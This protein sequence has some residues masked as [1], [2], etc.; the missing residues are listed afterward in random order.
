MEETIQNVV[1]LHDP[2]LVEDTNSDPVLTRLADIVL[3]HRG[4]PMEQCLYENAIVEARR[5]SDNSLPPGYKDKD[6]WKREGLEGGAGDYIVWEQFLQESAKRSVD[7]VFVTGDVKED[8]YVIQSGEAR[9]PR[10]ELAEEYASRTDGHRLFMIRSDS[11]I[12]HYSQIAKLTPVP[13]ASGSLGWTESGVKRLLTDLESGG[14]IA[15]ARVIL[16][17]IATGES[18]SRDRVYELANYPE[19]RSLRGFTRPVDRIM[20][21]MQNDGQ[22]EYYTETPLIPEYNFTETKN[23]QA[24]SFRLTSAFAN[25]ARQSGV[26]GLSPIELQDENIFVLQDDDDVW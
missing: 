2:D 17:S 22:I 23:N 16:E 6:K 3:G 25:A 18:V 21:D 26:A 5:R 7:G 15:Q 20:R 9:G 19:S 4:D 24:A 13:A 11:L 14:Y 10:N 1:S 12:F 8:W